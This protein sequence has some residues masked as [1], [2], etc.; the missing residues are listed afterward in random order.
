[1]FLSQGR[2][3]KL[4]FSHPALYL[5]SAVLILAIGKSLPENIIEKYIGYVV[6]VLI[7]LGGGIF[8]LR[9]Y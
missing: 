4:L 5:I 9:H 7:I 2:Q 1:L 8:K 3:I 6:F